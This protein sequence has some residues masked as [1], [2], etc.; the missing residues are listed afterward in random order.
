M[1]D[2]P[3]WPLVMRRSRAAAF[4]DLSAAQ[5][6]REVMVGRL[7]QPMML[8][9][10]PHWHREAIRE[11]LDLMAGRGGVPDWRKEQPGLAA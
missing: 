2:L 1:S 5:F 9:G 10:T 8:G 11:A 4:C 7:P 6:E 3:N